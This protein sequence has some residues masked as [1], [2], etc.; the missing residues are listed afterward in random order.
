MRID[1]ANKVLGRLASE[2]SK[3]LQ[4]KDKPSFN[5]RLGGNEVV[6]VENID[7]IKFTGKK[8]K[9]KIYYRYTGY[10]GGLKKKTLEELF[11]KSPEQVLKIA[12]SK[13]LPRNR[14]RKGRMKRLKIID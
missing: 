8:L 1:A 10:P 6:E 13:M 5:P 3:I 14:L 9:Q 2:I 12:V 4:G 7:K 11:E